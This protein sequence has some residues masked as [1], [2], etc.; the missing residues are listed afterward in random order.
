MFRCLLVT[1]IAVFV[2]NSA[3]AEQTKIEIPA[4]I[5]T[6]S[7]NVQLR[8][9]GSLR[10]M[11]YIN[12]NGYSHSIVF[13]D[14]RENCSVQIYAPSGTNCSSPKTPLEALI[15][16]E[17]TK[18][19]EPGS[20]YQVLAT[21]PVESISMVFKNL[22]QIMVSDSDN[23]KYKGY[24]EAK[25]SERERE[26]RNTERKREEEKEEKKQNEVI[27][28][29]IPKYVGGD[30]ILSLNFDG[31]VLKFT[32]N[33]SDFIVINSISTYLDSEIQTLSGLNIELPPESVG[34]NMNESNLISRDQRRARM[35]PRKDLNSIKKLKSKFGFAIKYTINGAEK[36]FYLVNQYSNDDLLRNVQ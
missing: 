20:L 4:S 19:V 11:A 18:Y 21:K 3:F 29:P 9:L 6:C 5:T 24:K 28:I 26:E 32:N 30:K 15:C 13:Y 7:W 10:E 22:N 1:I 23:E 12:H 2:T 33:S 25:N 14:L 8:I 27:N 34:A 17:T 36:K 16:G 35:I 31:S